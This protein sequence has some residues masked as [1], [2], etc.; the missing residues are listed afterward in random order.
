MTTSDIIN[1]V[2]GGGVTTAI[3]MV[4]RMRSDKRNTDSSTSKNDADAAAVI[5]ETALELLAPL[6]EEIQS[7]R[8]QVDGMRID[9]AEYH[10]RYGPLPA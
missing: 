6:R 1:L 5:S 4:Y 9:L 3:G 2:I 10:R 7:L 8:L